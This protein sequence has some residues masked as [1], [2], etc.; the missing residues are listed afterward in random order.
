MWTQVRSASWSLLAPAVAITAPAPVFAVDYL[1]ADQAQ[2]AMFP[3]ADRFEA[4]EVSLTAA[5]LAAVERNLGAPLRQA[6]WTLRLAWRGPALAGVVVVDDVIGKFERI[7]YAVGLGPD[8]LIHQVEVL[9]YRESHGQEVRLAAWRKQFVGKG[10][11]SPLRVGEDIAG[12]SGATLS[13]THVTEGVRRIA[14][15]VAELRRT[16]G[17]P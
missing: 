2:A 1:T 3:G 17:L 13:C 10:A 5:Q 15:V 8:G 12:I 16:G 7:T 9:S 11:A 4:R 6:H 14:S